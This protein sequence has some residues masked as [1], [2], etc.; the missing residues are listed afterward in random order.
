VFSR[1]KSRFGDI[2]TIK[3]L[4]LLAEKHALADQ[5]RAPGAEHFLLAALDLPE[6]TARQAFERIGADASTL[7][8]AIE[9]QYSDALCSLGV[10]PKVAKASADEPLPSKLGAYNAAPSGKEVMLALAANRREHGPLLGAHVV[11]VVAG[12]QHG[13]ASR[14]L[15]VMGIDANAL[16][17]SAI[18][19]AAGERRAPNLQAHS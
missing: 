1:I 17:S 2:D 18:E 10:D 19:I 5:L 16:K 11:A 14:A 9:R 3:T 15:R 8:Q 4:C 12:Q 13:V 6:D 7:R